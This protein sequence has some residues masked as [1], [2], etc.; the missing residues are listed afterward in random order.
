MSLGSP[1]AGKKSCITRCSIFEAT[2][3]LTSLVR[4]SPFCTYGNVI[5]RVGIDIW[6]WLAEYSA[7]SNYTY[8]C[9]HS[10]GPLL[11]PAV[12]DMLNLMICVVGI[13][14]IYC[15]ERWRKRS[16]I[17]YSQ[18]E[19]AMHEQRPLYTFA[20]AVLRTKSVNLYL[21]PFSPGSLPLLSYIFI[22]FSKE[23][24]L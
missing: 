22:S 12:R 14:S 11:K 24:Y 1:T 8:V 6:M 10:Y 15:V 20:P 13:A 19:A 17:R 16:K 3:D 4:F 5:R 2:L 21:L 23:G 18:F 9:S 7:N